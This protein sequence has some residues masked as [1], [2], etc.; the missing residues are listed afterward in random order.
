M[1]KTALLSILASTLVFAGGDIDPVEPVVDTPA[2]NQVDDGTSS[3]PMSFAL[4]GGVMKDEGSNTDWKAFYGAEL[5]FECLLSDSTRSQLQLTNYDHEGLQMLQL[6]ANPHYIFNRG[7]AV[8]FGAGPH[9]GV[10]RAEI[11][12]EDDTVFTY[13]LGASAR[14]DIGNNFF[15]GAEARYEWTTDAEFSGVKDDLNNAKVF[16]K[17]GYSF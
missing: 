12:N 5:A 14:A 8:E 13:G 2:F 15:V 7:D 3:I 10:A 11:G 9:I 4:L 16:A 6:S 17:L 1:K